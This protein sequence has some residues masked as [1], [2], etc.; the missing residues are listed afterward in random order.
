MFITIVSS[1]VTLG[2]WFISEELTLLRGL[3]LL[4]VLLLLWVFPCSLMYTLSLL[5]LSHEW[6]LSTRGFPLNGS[7]HCPAETA[8]LLPSYDGIRG[9]FPFCVGSSST[10]GLTC[11]R[12]NSGTQAGPRCSH[13]L[14]SHAMERGAIVRVVRSSGVIGYAVRSNVA[15][16]CVVRSSEEIDHAVRRTVLG[17][18]SCLGAR[19]S[20]LGRVYSRRLVLVTA[21]VCHRGVVHSRCVCPHGTS[22]AR[23][24]ARESHVRGCDNPGCCSD[25]HR[26]GRCKGWMVGSF[27]DFRLQ[28]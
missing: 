13:F 22:V 24:L 11:Y 19:K 14:P 17:R 12:H 4:R 9:C 1:S 18:L 21:G 2:I 25:E 23:V 16:G 3:S 28:H 6:V 5:L 27:D 20:Y 26:D 8:S 7:H 10:G 15:M